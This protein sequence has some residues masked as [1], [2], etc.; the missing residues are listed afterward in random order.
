MFVSYF[1]QINRTKR[2]R[3]R[4][5]WQDVLPD[6][7]EQRSAYRIADKHI[8]KFSRA[9]LSM[10]R[11]LIDENTATEIKDKYNRGA[12]PQE[13][14][15]LIPIFAEGIND[16][17]P[18]WKKFIDK[19]TGA[20][21][22]LIDESGKD[23]TKRMNKK[24][25][26]NLGF[27]MVAKRQ[28]PIVPVNPYSIEWIRTRALELI[29]TNLSISQREVITSVLT[30]AI[31]RGLRGKEVIDSIIQN[32]GLTPRD[33]AAVG[34]RRLLHEKAGLPK[35]DITRLVDKY[36]D[37]LVKRRAITISRTETI[38]AQAQGR[39]TAW[40]LA[41][42]SGQLPKVKRLWITA[43]SSPNPNRP[44]DICEGLDGAE[45]DLGEPYESDV[46]GFVQMPPAHPNCRCTETIVRVKE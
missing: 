16:D 31:S 43:P 10:I 19:I 45:A 5:D 44:C 40:Q 22:D 12:T 36:R 46:I 6:T 23:E 29:K 41:R 13:I 2:L 14:I 25:K 37:G 27:T 17:D 8:E 35:K 15:S 33:F 7:Q 21:F 20:Y 34:K 39:N 32:I 26:T 42:E 1:K 4:P 30:D 3:G 38:A 9:F 28:V 24:L 18:V 11:S